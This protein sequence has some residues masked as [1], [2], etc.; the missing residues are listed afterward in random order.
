MYSRSIRIV[1]ALCKA[2]AYSAE[3]RFNRTAK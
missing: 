3:R 1:A 2:A